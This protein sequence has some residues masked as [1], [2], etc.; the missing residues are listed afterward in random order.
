[1][2]NALGVIATV[3]VLSAVAWAQRTVA[4]QGK[5]GTEGPWPVVNQGGTTFITSD[6]G[7]IGAVATAPCL[8]YRETN[9]SVGAAA[10]LVPATPLANRLWVRICNSLRNT[11]SAICVCSATTTPT[12]TAASLGDPLAVSDCVLYPITSAD[13][14]VPL[15]IC[16]GAG[17]RLPTAECALK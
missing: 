17:V 1:M 7:F 12:F 15:C 9:T 4:N 6:G 2:K 8:H 3:M 5:P 11:P 16:N 10:A 13:A 14:G